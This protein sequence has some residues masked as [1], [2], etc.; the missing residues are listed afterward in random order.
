MSPG[1][2]GDRAPGRSEPGLTRGPR[3]RLTPTWLTPATAAAEQRDACVSLRPLCR[4]ALTPALLSCLQHFVSE[5]KYDE[6]L[7][8]AARFSCDIEQL[9][10]QI[11]LCGESEFAR[12]LSDPVPVSPALLGVDMSGAVPRGLKRG[13]TR[14]NDL[15]A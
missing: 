10:A 3:S 5:R 15:R 7:G 1:Q 6:E 2:E 12:R 11:M 14:F 8:K 4:V 13:P 9:K